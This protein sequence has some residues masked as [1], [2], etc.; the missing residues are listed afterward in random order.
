MKGLKRILISI[1]IA[2]IGFGAAVAFA[3]TGPTQSPPNGN[4]PAPINVGT[5][6]QV[7]N[8][9]LSVNSLAVFGNGYVQN[10]LTLG[11][12]ALPFQSDY[13]AG[14]WPLEIIG[15]TY[16]IWAQA[17]SI[18]IHGNSTGGSGIEGYTSANGAFGV[19]G[20]G[21]QGVYGHAYNVTGPG[22]ETP[23]GGW[24]VI[25]DGTDGVLGQGTTYPLRG[26]N[27]NSG[28][29]GDIG[30]NGYSFY[31]NGPEMATAYNV[32]SDRRL[33]DNIAASDT[34]L[35]TLM[36]IPVDDF[37]FIADSNS[38][39][40]QGFIAQALLPIYPEA[41]TTNGDNGIVPLGP[42]STPW[43]VDY[44]RLTPLIVK[45]VQDIGNISST[46]RQRLVAWLG[47]STNGIDDLFAKTLHAQNTL[48][49]DN[50]AGEPICI[51]GD[52]LAT[53]LSQSTTTATI[54]TTR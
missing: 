8:G 43:S 16:G 23:S 53:L 47:S 14:T 51:T 22:T 49:I 34:G 35:A 54:T 24:G 9:G 37:N 50:S 29:Y 42:T 45:S 40:V 5:S 27:L 31:G 11:T 48:C 4:V 1:S 20:H 46:F 28:I 39:K 41:V 52:Q 36:Q 15:G 32:L 17:S 18:A 3:W 38:P 26:L 21:Y 7:K 6:N 44:G 13:A 12:G 10:Q 2:T 30:Y 33:K 25:G 19:V